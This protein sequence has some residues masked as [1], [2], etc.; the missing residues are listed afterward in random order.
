MSKNQAFYQNR[1]IFLNTSECIFFRLKKNISKVDV[2]ILV[3]LLSFGSKFFLQWNTANL[4]SVW[5]QSFCI[6]E[7]AE[8]FNL[9][10]YGVFIRTVKYLL[11]RTIIRR[12]QLLLLMSLPSCI[13]IFFFNLSVPIHKAASSFCS[14]CREVY[15]SSFC[16]SAKVFSS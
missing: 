9:F 1:S 16:I 7:C 5:L 6:Q 10:W 8:H 2:L 11:F 13:S 3:G 12:F 15:F 14:H 4:I